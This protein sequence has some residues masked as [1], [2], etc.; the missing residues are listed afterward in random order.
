MRINLN[1]L[2][3]KSAGEKMLKELAEYEE[4]ADGLE[5]EIRQVMKDRGGI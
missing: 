5:T 3:D 1:T 2:E 4:Q